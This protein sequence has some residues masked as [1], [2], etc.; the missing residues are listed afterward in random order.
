MT[1]PTDR[2]GFFLKLNPCRPSFT[3]DMTDEEKGVMM[4]HVGYWKALRDK[5][6]VVAL[7]PVM[8]P[9]G[10]FGLGIIEVDSDEQIKEFMANDPAVKSGVG[11]YEFYPMRIGMR[12]GS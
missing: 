8:D 9:N 1:N 6:F 3:L 4:Q 2:K 12:W 5:G 10:G 7:G 11:T